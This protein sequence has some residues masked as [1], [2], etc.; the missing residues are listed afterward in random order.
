MLH[1]FGKF[2]ESLLK[3]YVSQILE[4]LTYLHDH[5]VV[6]RDIKAANI[7]VESGGVCKVAGITSTY[8]DFGSSK[9]LNEIKKNADS[10]RSIQGTPNFM[11]PEVVL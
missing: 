10:Y 6:H 2:K 5:G 7:L 11:A 9:R 8:Q 1:K 4:G 3:V